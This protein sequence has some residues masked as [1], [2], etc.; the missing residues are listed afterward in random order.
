MKR[1]LLMTVAVSVLV[2]GSC[3]RTPPT[4]MLLV[5]GS[6]T[7]Q[8]YIANIVAAFAKR[9]PTINVVSDAGG[10][11][12]GVI[13]LKRGAIDV[14][15]IARDLT[16]D[17]DDPQIR[18][19]LVAKD[20]LAIIVSSANPVSNLTMEQLRQIY[21][22]KIV[23]WKAL[24]GPDAKIEILTREPSAKV[25]RSL[26]DLVLRGDEMPVGRQVNSRQEMTSAVK[27]SPNAMGF[28][29]LRGLTD[30]VK[31]LTID[32]V[33]MSRLTILSSRY[34]LSRSFYVALYGLSTPAA[35]KLVSFT[36]SAE[37]QAIFAEDGLIPVR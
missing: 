18:N 23:S 15:L 33:A 7:M 11:A 24:G 8:R 25:Q 26:R 20:G 36:L 17:E 6:T 29:S 21:Q 22:E 16:N 30:D 34:P 31:A 35:E 5:A 13:A 28:V 1:W 19:Y 2:L 9:E 37:G 32:G 4:S 27:A 14:A 3:R 12:A 10:A